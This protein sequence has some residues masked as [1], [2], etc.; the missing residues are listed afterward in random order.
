MANLLKSVN[1]SS[2]LSLPLLQRAVAIADE[3]GLSFPS[4][5]TFYFNLGQKYTPTADGAALGLNDAGDV[6]GALR[7][8]GE[9]A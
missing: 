6:E 5:A 7:S 1:G 3:A 4:R 2:S 8:V 9:G